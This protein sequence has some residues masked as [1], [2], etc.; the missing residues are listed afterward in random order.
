MIIMKRTCALLATLLGLTSQVSLAWAQQPW[1]DSH[2]PHMMWEGGWMFPG[3]LMMLL[4]AAMI[5][6]LVVLVFRWLGARDP[7]RQENNA[8]NILKER[9]ARGEIDNEEFEERTRVLNK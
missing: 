7:A 1:A 8:L 3:L 5:V 2:G 4:F 6:A 9:Y